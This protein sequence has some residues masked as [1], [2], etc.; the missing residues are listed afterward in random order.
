[1]VGDEDGAGP[2]ID[3]TPG[4]SRWRIPFRRTGRGDS[5]VS[6]SGS[7]QLIAGLKTAVITPATEPSIGL[8]P[9][10]CRTPLKNGM[11]RELCGS[12][13]LSRQLLGSERLRVELQHRERSCVSYYALTN[14]APPPLRR[15][16]AAV[17]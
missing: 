11:R 8:D 16:A 15:R 7:S 12:A 13:R 6:Q 5:R 2:V 9:T 10:A 4:S 14:G 17:A 1:M 3:G